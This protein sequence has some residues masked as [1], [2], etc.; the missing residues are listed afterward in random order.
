MLTLITTVT[1]SGRYYY[2]SCLTDDESELREQTE[3]QA[4]F[5]SWTNER[6]YCIKFF[7]APTG[8]KNYQI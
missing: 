1:L 4:S 8:F 5:I 6:D 3:Q 7:K 2:Y